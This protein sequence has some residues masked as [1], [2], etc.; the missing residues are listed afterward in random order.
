MIPYGWVV[1][2][3]LCAVAIGVGCGYFVWLRL[4]EKQR[5]ELLR[6]EIVQEWWPT[7]D[8]WDEQFKIAEKMAAHRRRTQ[9]GRSSV[10]RDDALPPAT[11]NRVVVT[12]R[13][14]KNAHRL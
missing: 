14:S 3:V 13:R 9:I 2:M 5:A 4:W 8:S 10:P 7:A 1:V 12:N 6:K 11:L